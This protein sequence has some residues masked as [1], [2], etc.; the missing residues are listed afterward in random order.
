MSK[1]SYGFWISEKEI[2][3]LKKYKEDNKLQSQSIALIK[4]IEE[5]KEFNSN[6]R[7]KEIDKISNTISK[8]IIKNIKELI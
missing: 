1:K 8:K 5:H 3:Y 6:K 2:D 7:E 4:I